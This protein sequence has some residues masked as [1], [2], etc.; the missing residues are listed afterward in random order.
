MPVLPTAASSIA[1]SNGAS[2]RSYDAP[3]ESIALKVFH[4]GFAGG[5]DGPRSRLALARATIEV[6]VFV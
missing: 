2:D 6:A 3:D 5:L 1:R 4:G